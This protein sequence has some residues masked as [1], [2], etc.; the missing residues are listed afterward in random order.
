MR[1]H[2]SSAAS[3][4]SFP[5]RPAHAAAASVAATLLPALL[6]L[7]AVLAFG[8]PAAAHS[9]LEAAT[10]KPNAHL[11]AAPSKLVMS[12]SEVPSKDS[13]IEVLDGCKRSVVQTTT[14]SQ[15][16]LDIAVATG[17]PGKWKVSYRVISAEDGHLTQGSYSFEVAGSA[18]CGKKT[19]PAGGGG[20]QGATSDGGGG[21]FPV[22]PVAVAGVVIVG[23]GLAVRRFSAR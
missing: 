19:K 17:Q 15:S 6:A 1:L 16:D 10:P 22:V 11:K 3:A 13:V 18:D 2:P 7:I 12:F 21:D 4:R 14:V 5:G 9:E 20:S 23:V 8:A